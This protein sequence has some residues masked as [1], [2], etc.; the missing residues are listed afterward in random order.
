MSHFL[1]FRLSQAQFLRFLARFSFEA[2]QYYG[3]YCGISH[4]CL[5]NLKLFIQIF[6][7]WHKSC[8][9]HIYDFLGFSK[10]FLEFIN[11]PPLQHHHLGVNRLNVGRKIQKF[12]KNILKH[13]KSHIYASSD[14]YVTVWKSL[15]KVLNF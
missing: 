3:R 12:Q 14:T 9:W 15:Y 2:P 1:V 5:K 7:L 6:K 4:F 8:Y 11:F 13:P 10:Y